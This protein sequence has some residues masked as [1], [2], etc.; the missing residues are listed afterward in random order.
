MLEVLL[1]VHSNHKCILF[2]GLLVSYDPHVLFCHPFAFSNSNRRVDIELS[3]LSRVTLNRFLDWN[4]KREN[5]KLLYV[6]L[7]VCPSKMTVHKS[8]CLPL[9]LYC[10]IPLSLYPSIP[11][12]LYPSIPQSLY[13]SIP[14]SL[15]LS[16]SLSTYQLRAIM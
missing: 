7:G 16:L 3:S 4:Y 2:L 5:I 6:I 10:S 8:S 15:S 14:L 12:S 9:L 11:Q 13:A 1:N